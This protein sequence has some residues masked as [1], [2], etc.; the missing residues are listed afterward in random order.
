M[1]SMKY[2]IL[3]EKELR[4]AKN[5]SSLGPFIYRTVN[6]RRLQSLHFHLKFFTELISEEA[7][8]R[9]HCNREDQ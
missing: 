1:N 9:E 7:S 2:I 3:G 5:N 6:I 4:K 8:F